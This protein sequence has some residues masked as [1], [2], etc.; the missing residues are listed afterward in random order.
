MVVPPAA[1]DFQEKPG[2]RRARW[3]ENETE[4][5]KK[6]GGLRT[7]VGRFREKEMHREDEK[8]IWAERCVMKEE[9]MVGKDGERLRRR[10][11]LL[12]ENRR[13]WGDGWSESSGTT[14]HQTTRGGEKKRGEKRTPQKSELQRMLKMWGSLWKREKLCSLVNL[15]WAEIWKS[16]EPQQ[17]GS[18]RGS[19]NGW[20]V[21]QGIILMKIRYLPPI[22]VQRRWSKTSRN[23]FTKS[24][25]DGSISL[26]IYE[27]NKALINK[28]S[29]R[30]NGCGMLAVNQ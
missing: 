6:R 14:I 1:W 3:W 22:T 25:Q 5:E 29:E 12:T 11:G 9:K 27:K 16:G 19:R 26:L 2:Q 17:A 10:K 30:L 21:R 28:Q 13:P 8:S 18:R 24:L 4:G 15:V 7:K 20:E 23:S